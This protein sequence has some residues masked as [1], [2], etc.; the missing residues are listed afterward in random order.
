M[1]E[2]EA[3]L[4]AWARSLSLFRFVRAIGGHAND[5][6]SLDVLFAVGSV[7]A[8][9][10]F[11][12]GAGVKPEV[13]SSAPPQPVVGRPYTAGEMAGFPSLIPGTCWIAQPGHCS[14]S[15]VPVFL[16]CRL[17]GSGWSITISLGTEYEVTAAD[18]GNAARLEPLL[19]DLPA[20]RIDPPTDSERCLC[21]KY[22]P[23]LFD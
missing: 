8:L 20:Q 16:W 15:G 5:S 9:L 6:D 22:H 18:V 7:E 14:V 19:R 17:R 4:R 12:E 11:L 21:P 3:T 2:S 23:E 10:G 1:G 13:Y